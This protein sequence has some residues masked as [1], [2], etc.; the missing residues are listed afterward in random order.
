MVS[1]NQTNNQTLVIE[2]HDDDDDLFGGNDDKLERQP[3]FAPDQAQL[4]TTAPVEAPAAEVPEE[5][6]Q[7]SL[8]GMG[9]GLKLGDDD[10]EDDDGE[11]LFGNEDKN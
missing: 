8:L 10:S 7:P 3:S 2:N 6:A 11:N 5:Q 4:F 9:M 1:A